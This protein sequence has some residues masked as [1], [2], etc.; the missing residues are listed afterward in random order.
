M[1]KP[2]Q[3]TILEVGPRDGFQNVRVQIPTED[4][5]GVVNAL[6]EAGLT[7]IETSSFV[8]PRWIPQLKDAEEVFARIRKPA[9]VVFSALIP[10]ERGLDRAI[11]AGV[12]QVCY[13]IAA[14]E[15]FSKM[16]F[17]KGVDEALALVP[18]LGRTAAGAGVSFRVSIACAFGCSVEGPIP[19][20][21]VLSIG[22]R[23]REAGA[24]QITL[25]DSMGIS[26]PAHV[27]DT[28]G[29]FM[30]DMGDYP[31]S[32][33]FHDRLGIG[34]VNSYAAVNAGVRIIE[35]SIA[36]LGGDPLTPGAVGNVATEELAYLL[37]TM[38]FKTGIDVEK[39]RAAA[40][41]LRLRLAA[42]E[43]DNPPDA[44]SGAMR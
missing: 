4:K 13:V 36:G 33:H 35:S 31:V 16:V 2:E 43:R 28:V 26:G 8:H 12:T 24:C 3:V 18:A 20:D 41:A 6:V 42:L 40:E 39:V 37:Q 34:M 44:S 1:T 38:G 15:T 23:L 17:N 27:A 22:R 7:R 32:V 21:R 11:A 9:G 19:F 29:R 5:I 10:N 14:S 25:A 30:R